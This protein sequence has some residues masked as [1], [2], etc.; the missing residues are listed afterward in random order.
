MSTTVKQDSIMCFSL[1]AQDCLDHSKA[2]LTGSYLNQCW[3]EHQDEC[4]RMETFTEFNTENAVLYFSYRH[5]RTEL[6]K[7]IDTLASRAFES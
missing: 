6:R 1:K 5:V 4:V 3:H 2:S 7:Y